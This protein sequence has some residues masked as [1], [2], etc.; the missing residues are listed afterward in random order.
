MPLSFRPPL[1]RP[2]RLTPFVVALASLK[3][4]LP[5]FIP[6]PW[7]FHRDELLYL[8]MGDHLD[9]L[10]MQF[11]PLIALA[12]AAIDGL[13][14]GTV[15][16]TRLAAAIPS[17]LYLVIAALIARDM[18]G[19]RRAQVFTALGVLVA[20][21]FLRAGILFQPVVYEQLWWLMSCWALVRLLR[22]DLPGWWLLLGVAVGLA[23][24]T[25][26]SAAFFALGLLMAVLFSPLRADL[27][28]PWPWLALLLA[29]LVGL[30]TITGQMTWSWPFF[31]QARVLR[32]TQL[33]RVTP[34]AF[35]GGQLFLLTAAAPFAIVGLAALAAARVLE[36]WRPLAVLVFV[37]TSAF[38]VAGAKDYYLA[39]LHGL[40]IAA[41][42]V[43]LERWIGDRSQRLLVSLAALSMV[44]VGL[45]L[46]PAALP[47][48]TPDGTVEYLRGLG[49]A[50]AT[51]T[52]RGIQLELPQDYAD[53]LGWRELAEAT[54]AVYD[55]LPADERARV[56]IVGTNYGRAGA[57]QRYG[58]ALGLPAPISRN[59][60]FYHWGPGDR[61]GDVAIVVGG[62][63]EALGQVFG[64]V[65]LV[66]TVANPLGVQEERAVPIFICRD[67]AQP[68]P[69]LW[70]QL[71]PEWG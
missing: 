3:L 53:M 49:L 63:V 56:V 43:A 33:E 45:V 31:E 58:P 48:L 64:S 10:R 52:N 68:L 30:P 39:P 5:F 18:G 6:R 16:G 17:T 28:G 70:R 34:L 61:P 36:P 27:R 2:Q 62:S 15:L 51:E 40:L 14:G 42:A 46:L 44:V 38:L 69:E 1:A 67:L 23:A 66:R 50:R 54:R 19:G 60:D 7:E 55:S 20:P 8:A 13:A 24:L 4:M 21:I 57:L 32:D 12:A 41:G 71:G 35:L 22:E 59:G 65:T 26:F 29:I 37:V 47:V 25:K 11:P 9:L